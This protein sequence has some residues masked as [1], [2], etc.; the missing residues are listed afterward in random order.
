ML[1]R[2]A[3]SLYWIGRN[4]ERADHTS[5]FLKVQYF[6]TLDTPML[7]SKD[8][9][10]RSIM[11]MAGTNYQIQGELVEKEVW[12]NVVFDINNP[13]T[14]FS[15]IKNAR[16]NARSIRN[17]LSIEI[18]ESINKLYLLCSTYDQN[19]FGSGDLFKFSE[20]MKS[21]ISVVKSNIS[22]TILHDD[23]Y[24][25]ICMGIFIERALQA[26][27]I[28]R[29]KISDWLILSDN[30]ENKPL[31]SYQWTI[32]LKSLEAYD[33]YNKLWPG[34]KTKQN[35]FKLIFE[36]ENFPRSV[37]YSL[38]KITSSISK[39]SVRPEGYDE[40]LGYFNS[41]LVEAAKF[42]EFDDEDSVIG[43]VDDAYESIAKI[44]SD[45]SNMYFN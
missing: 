33:I 24:H 40:L 42:D 6:S 14:L 8:F 10:L 3:E 21:N 18:W 45:I 9:T 44:H 28:V 17:S 11:F 1:A 41:R 34:V 13:N 29:N 20:N 38:S 32:L 43:H 35:M 16:E 22:N 39:I 19:S 26:L 4:I 23:S 12:K 15:I 5:R 7:R 36:N 30:G 37:A 31:V 25:F 2:V 27:R